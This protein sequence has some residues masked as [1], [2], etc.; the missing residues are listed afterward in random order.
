[1]GQLAEAKT[2][3][4]K[5]WGEAMPHYLCLDESMYRREGYE[6]MKAVITP[7]LRPKDHQEV[8]W[9]GL[10]SGMMS[11]VGSDHC[12]FP[13]KDKIRLYEQFGKSFDKIPHGA[14]GI[15]TRM[16]IIFSEGVL[17]GRLSLTKYVEIT[18]S[19][20]ARIAGI[21]PQKGTLAV[22]SDADVVIMDPEKEKTLSADILHGKTDFTPFEGF[23]VKGWPAMT[24]S[25][26]KVLIEGDEVVAAP[27]SGQLLKRDKFVPF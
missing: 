25:R 4:V 19:N 16:P 3:G 7:P 14:P 15:E 13:F 27:G 20:P 24:M 21:Y 12:A 11:T 17:K 9:Q 2:R 5:I 6:P 22:G 23:V 1:M 18:A 8:L 26:G 10:R